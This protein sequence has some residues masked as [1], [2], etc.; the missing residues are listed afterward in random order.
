MKIVM[1]GS[2]NVA[3]HLAVAFH[4]VGHQIVQVWSRDIEHAQR[5]AVRVGAMPL[6][7]VGRLALTVD[8]YILAVSDDALYQLPQQLHFPNAV[9]VHTSGSVAG[10]VLQRVSPHHGVLWSPQTFIRDVAMDYEALPFCVE[11]SDELALQTVT[12]L[13]QTVSTHICKLSSNQRRWAHL[14]A[15]VVN[16]FGNALNAAAERLMAKHG[17]PFDLLLPIIDA[18]ANKAHKGNLDKQQ[19]GPAVRHD[20][21]TIDA[22][23]RLLESEPELLRLYDVMTNIIQQCNS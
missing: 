11:G 6:D 12:A 13:A 17:I 4:R 3:T 15:V 5:L 16:N 7:D 19:T 21:K 2:G 8:V 9:V 14:S 20:Q 10:D 23:R 18:T 22:H 1:I